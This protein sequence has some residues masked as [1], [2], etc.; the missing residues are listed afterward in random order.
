MKKV[1]RQIGFIAQGWLGK[2][3]ANDFE[4]RG[5]SVVRCALEEP[6]VKIK[7]LL[8]AVKLR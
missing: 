7:S 5:Y 4:E 3:Y 2:N 1:S 8:K 6:Y